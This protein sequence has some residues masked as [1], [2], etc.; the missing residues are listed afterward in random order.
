MANARRD[1]IDESSDA[2][3]PA[4]DP[5]SWAPLRAGAPQHDD[6]A[7]NEHDRPSRVRTKPD[8][9]PDVRA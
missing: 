3:F 2:S 8:D 4:S 7:T 9:V 1:R 5:P 6:V